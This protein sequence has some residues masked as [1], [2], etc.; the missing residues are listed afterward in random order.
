MKSHILLIGEEKKELEMFEEALLQ[1]HG[2]VNCTYA[3]EALHALEA[4]RRARPDIVFINFA[5]Q[6]DSSLQVLSVIKSEPV[7]KYIRVFLYA[8]AISEEV[9]KMAR[10]LGASGCLEKTTCEATL[11]REL[12]AILDPQLLPGYIFLRRLN[13]FQGTLV[14]VD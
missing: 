12:Q 2:A 14:C 10:V 3:G 8:E 11:R 9:N 4:I 5:T 1:V 13:D 7:L 6:P